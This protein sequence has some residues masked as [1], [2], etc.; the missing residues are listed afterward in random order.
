MYI[1]KIPIKIKDNPGVNKS[2]LRKKYK[3]VNTKPANNIVIARINEKIL[4]FFIV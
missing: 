4:K 3:A 2:F 1:K